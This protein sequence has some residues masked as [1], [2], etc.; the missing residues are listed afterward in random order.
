MVVQQVADLNILVLTLPPACCRALRCRQSVLI[1][2]HR[3]TNLGRFS[4]TLLDAVTAIL[5]GKNP[6]KII[7][8]EATAELHLAIVALLKLGDHRRS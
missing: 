8:L 1:Q 2:K 3:K 4:S 5:L 6:Y 7:E